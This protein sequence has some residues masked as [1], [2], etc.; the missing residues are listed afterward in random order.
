MIRLLVRLALVITAVGAASLLLIRVRAY[1]GST[2]DHFFNSCTPMPCWQGIHPG[3][4]TTLDA[5]LIL[6]NHPW[7]DKIKIAL[8]GSTT[9]A[10]DTKTTL[11]YWT[12]SS[13]YPYEGKF[14]VQQGIVIT[15]HGIVQQIYLTTDI[16]LGDFWLKLGDPD[17]GTVD[18]VY[19]A[20]YLRVDNTSLYEKDG[21]AATASLLG[22]C[23]N[24]Y[25]NFWQAQVYLWLQ[26]GASLGV[27][28]VAY[29]VYQ[30]MLRT[31]YH[32]V[33]ASMC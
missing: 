15:D 8:A 21:V 2:L 31:G 3:E 17:S 30:D 24:V 4:T 13:K 11:I 16:P 10:S 19:D 28:N 23:S 25:A 6:Q 20:N 18:Y 14:P 7:I 33:R 27:G 29:P 9:S 26:S 1:D 12:W 32:R 5:L 22:D